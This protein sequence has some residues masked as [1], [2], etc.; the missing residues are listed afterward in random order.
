MPR[1]K[2]KSGWCQDKSEVK[3]KPFKLANFDDFACEYKSS[4]NL[5]CVKMETNC[6]QTTTTYG[7]GKI[8]FT[9]KELGQNYTGGTLKLSPKIKTGGNAGP[10][11][12]EG[13]IGANI[14]IELDEN[15][16]VKEWEG[17]VTAGVEGGIG[18]NTGP[19]KIGATIGEALE[20]E[21]GSN[22]ISDINIVSTGKI[23]A[24]IEAPKSDGDQK[25]DE[26]INK[27]I[28]YINKGIGKL[29]TSVELGVESRTSLISGH[30]S[31]SGT[32]LLSGVKMSEW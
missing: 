22:G 26:Q 5:G 15:N 25:I 32:G 14:I 4:L 3:A 27:G 2:D 10:L 8:S 6:G 28:G 19:V 1:F 16:H 13:F 31:V 30:G 20:V 11:S 21:L 24:G 18:T 17:K 9:E 29:N 23:E 7:C 12:A